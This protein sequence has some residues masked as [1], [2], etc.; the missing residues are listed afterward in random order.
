MPY[1]SSHLCFRSRNGHILVYID[2]SSCF[3]F[4]NLF[5]CKQFYPWQFSVG[6]TYKQLWCGCAIQHKCAHRGKAWLCSFRIEF[7]GKLCTLIQLKLHLLHLPLRGGLCPH[8]CRIELICQLFSSP[9]QFRV[10]AFGELSKLALRLKLRVG[11][12]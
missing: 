12:V 8:I 5:H 2:R 10:V 1:A 3:C 7:S 6:R 9:L 4:N 11:L